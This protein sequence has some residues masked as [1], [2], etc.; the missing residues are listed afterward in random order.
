MLHNWYSFMFSNI[1]IQYLHLPIHTNWSVFDWLIESVF[2]WLNEWISVWLW[3]IKFLFLNNGD[4]NH[5]IPRTNPNPHN[6]LSIATDQ[7]RV[8]LLK[9]PRS[10]YDNWCITFWLHNTLSY[11]AQTHFHHNLSYT[12]HTISYHT[13]SKLENFSSNPKWKVNSCAT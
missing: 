3:I 12:H 10:N 9:I 11:T 4:I 6:S 13:I 2:D 7:Q 1:K 8:M 5:A